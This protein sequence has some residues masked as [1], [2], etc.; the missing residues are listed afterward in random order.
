[1]RP[2]ARHHHHHHQEL[3]VSHTVACAV[4]A[5]GDAVSVAPPV[6]R[7]TDS[8]LFGAYSADRPSR[9]LPVP[10]IW[11]ASARARAGARGRASVALAPMLA[12]PCLDTCVALACLVGVILAGTVILALAVWGCSIGPLG[13][14]CAALWAALAC[15]GVLLIVCWYCTQMGPFWPI[16]HCMTLCP[17]R[18]ATCCL[19]HSD[20]RRPLA[21]APCCPL[22]APCLYQSV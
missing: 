12:S 2:P 21:P 19:R 5:A 11:S 7:S 15:L 22:A 3:T 14:S 10:A 8:P 18:V 17:P 16:I 6:A 9:A 13:A 20:P 1:L 4:D